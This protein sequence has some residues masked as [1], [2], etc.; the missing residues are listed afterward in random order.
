MKRSENKWKSLQFCRFARVFGPDSDQKTIYDDTVY[1][2]LITALQ[3]KNSSCFAYGPTGAGEL[4]CSL[5]RQLKQIKI[6]YSC[7]RFSGKTFTILGTEDQPGLIPRCV[8]DLCHLVEQE[9]A[10]EHCEW[11]IDVSFSYTEIY[12]EKVTGFR[13]YWFPQELEQIELL[14]LQLGAGLRACPLP[15]PTVQSRNFLFVWRFEIC[16]V[17][18]TNPW[19]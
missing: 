13:F 8:R 10:S 9:R 18:T 14:C 3:G 1:P 7:N 4:H 11:K 17:R 19:P 2:L 6:S 15:L 5:M 12:N 16:W